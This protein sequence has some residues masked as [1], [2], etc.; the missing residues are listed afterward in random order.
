VGGAF[1]SSLEAGAER[2]ADAAVATHG[3][4]DVAGASAPGIALSPA[5][6]DR[7]GADTE[8]VPTEREVAVADGAAAWHQWLTQIETMRFD[9]AAGRWTI[10]ID[11]QQYALHEAQHRR[12]LNEANN[13]IGG[14]IAKLRQG[15]ERA[16]RIDKGIRE[17]SQNG[18]WANLSI[19]WVIEH[20]Y[21]VTPPGEKLTDAVREAR[22]Y[23]F[24]AA[25]A[26]RKGEFLTAFEYVESGRVPAERA[27]RLATDYYDGV[28]AAT[29]SMQD[30][31]VGSWADLLQLL[32]GV[33]KGIGSQATD[34]ADTAFWATDELRSLTGGSTSGLMIATSLSGPLAPIAAPTVSALATTH[35]TL[36]SMGVVDPSGRV[37][38]TAA[39][40]SAMEGASKDVTQSLGS[41]VVPGAILGPFDVGDVGGSL[42]VQGLLAATGVKEITFAADLV[43]AASSLRTVINTY[44]DNPDWKSDTNFWS[45]AIGVGLGLI[46]L[47]HWSGTKRLVDYALKSGQVAT[48]IPPIEQFRRDMANSEGLDEAEQNRRLGEDI[49]RFTQAVFGLLQAAHA[50]RGA[51]G[52]ADAPPPTSPRGTQAEPRAPMVDVP[53]VA[54][55]PLAAPRQSRRRHSGA[56]CCPTSRGRVS[57]LPR[58]WRRQGNCCKGHGP[59]RLRPRPTHRLLRQTPSGNRWWPSTKCRCKWPWGRPGTPQLGWAQRDPCWCTTPKPS[60]PVRVRGPDP[61]RGQD[62]A[63]GSGRHHRQR[64]RACR[65]KP[66]RRAAAAAVPRGAG[67]SRCRDA[68]AGPISWAAKSWSVSTK[69]SP[70]RHPPVA[71]KKSVRATWWRPRTRRR[72]AS[73]NPRTSRPTCPT[74]PT[75][76]S[77]R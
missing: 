51:A 60:S 55:P 27:A 53:V 67:P 63:A 14:Q 25:E 33:L 7:S 5:S 37:S 26:Q 72:C 43:G 64:R 56:R 65:R 66:R 34:L 1:A 17:I 19:T 28:K 6:S 32:L 10:T 39:F 20:Y 3:L 74:R 58:R 31:I 11:G 4:V 76:S 54:P 41:S 44:R 23:A 30:T 46:G 12:N 69:S 50:S 61:V 42:A 36:K 21:R 16:D 40:S 38:T 59:M 22:A 24:Q 45:G 73:G 13:A 57:A 71:A 2:A 18:S 8:Q 15:T 70:S 47:G 68:R 62:R 49:K 48:L 77:A 35:D 52:G 75:R 9:E 29:Q